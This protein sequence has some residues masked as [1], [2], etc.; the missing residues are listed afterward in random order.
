MVSIHAAVQRLQEGGTS[1]P[2]LSQ[3]QNNGSFTVV[4]MH[5]VFPKIIT[6]SLVEHLLL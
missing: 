3:R 5:F 2:S 4:Y 1:V 6:G